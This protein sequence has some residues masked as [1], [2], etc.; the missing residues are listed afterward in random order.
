M[1]T[2]TLPE[3]Y[4]PPARK[5]RGV[6]GRVFENI[7]FGGASITEPPS[8]DK[9][10]EIQSQLHPRKPRIKPTAVLEEYEEL[11]IDDSSSDGKRKKT[12]VN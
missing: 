1:K 9:K 7:T 12:M 8:P 3:L 5:N 10:K 4:V 2:E 11:A 6:P